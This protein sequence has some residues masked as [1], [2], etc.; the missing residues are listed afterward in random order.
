MY[1]FCALPR[2][3]QLRRPGAWC[4]QCPRW[5][6][7]LNHL[8]GTG[9][10]VSWV[11]HRT[12]SQVCHVSP[13]GSWSQALTFLADVS[14]PGS[15]E[16]MV[17]N[18]EPTHALVEDAVSG[19]DIAPHLPALAVGHLQCGR[20]RSTAASCGIHSVLC[21]MRRPGCSLSQSSSW[22][23]YCHFFILTL[24][25]KPVT[26]CPAPTHW[27]QMWASG[28][29]LHW[30]LQLSAYSLLFFFFFSFQLCCPLRFQNSQQTCWWECFL[31]FGNFS[32][33]TTP[34]QGR[35]SIPNSFVSLFVF[36]IL[37]YLLL[38]FNF[39]WPVLLK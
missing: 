5:A 2:S 12:P 7:R 38:R 8:P 32:S 15:Q 11:R 22:E 39:N 35:V 4:V 33:F 14:H 21:S 24:S 17:T 13:L 31:M 3:E 36:Y 1:A 37:S 6:V 16:D 26:P 25:M 10:S 19:T 28:V 29:L 9:H 34:S 23:S 27:W 30:Q 20:G 18:R